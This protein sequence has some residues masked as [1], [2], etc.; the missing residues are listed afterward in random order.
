M[1]WS[2]LHENGR[3]FHLT[4]DELLELRPFY[5]RADK[6]LLERVVASF[7]DGCPQSEIEQ[8][9]PDAQDQA[10]FGLHLGRGIH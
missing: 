6:A 8:R 1:D 7:L 2:Q 5:E 3:R 4:D 9:Y 10:R